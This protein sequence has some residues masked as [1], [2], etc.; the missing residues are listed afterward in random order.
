MSAPLR[1]FEGYGVELEYMLVSRKDLSTRPIADLILEELAGET[2]SEV[3][4]G[5]VSWSNEFVLHVI[6][7]KNTHPAAA[8]PPLA[9]EFASHVR[10]M[11]RRLEAR[12]VMLLPSA[13][14]P[15][16]RPGEEV[17]L[18]PHEGREIYETFD[19][20]FDCRRHGWANLQSAQINLS[21]GDDEEFGRLHAAVRLVLPIL[22]AIAASSPLIEGELTGLMD[23]RLEVY[24]TNALR[25]PSVTGRVIPEP[26]FSKKE[27][28]S[29]VLAPM[30]EEVAP[31][32]P[33]GVLR[34]PW[35]NARGAIAQFARGAVEIRVIDMQERPAAD[36]AV[37]AAAAAVVRGL[38]EGRFIDQ[39]AQKRWP[40]EPLEAIFL[41]TLRDAE[42][43][44]IRD[45]A[46]LRVFD[47]P[48][49]T[50]RASELWGHVLDV[51]SLDSEPLRVIREDGPLARRMTRFAGPS[52]GRQRIEELYRRLAACL[53]VGEAFRVV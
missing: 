49:R 41:A 29:L 51:L 3:E 12:G 32:D 35:L 17:R 37:C 20:I 6:E 1:L 23:T 13:M 43:T 52:P 53:D 36:I 14:H 5:L 33:E 25:L 15:W 28:E 2:A 16:M 44:V 7:L 47:F 42:E 40:I 18:W 45:A 8:L 46:Y 34:H 19:R 11:N 39:S 38:I 9:E 10:E 50:A 4:V 22:A 21:F 24:R 31:Y 26:V 48:E 27:Y 30:Y